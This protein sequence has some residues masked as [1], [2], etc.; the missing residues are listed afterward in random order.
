VRDDNLFT[1]GGVTAGI[2]FALTLVAEMCGPDV[3]QA[4]QLQIEYAPA[5]PFMA[6][7][8]DTAPT[9]VLDMAHARGAGMRAEREVL[10]GRVAARLAG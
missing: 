6:G 4:V 1:G 8:P 5:P 10:M 2:D 3:A 9:R 7:S